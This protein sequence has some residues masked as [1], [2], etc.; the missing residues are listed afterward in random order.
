[1][2]EPSW[3][4]GVSPTCDAMCV[5]VFTC[6]QSA[7]RQ[8]YGH[9][10]LRHLVPER[11]HAVTSQTQADWLLAVWKAA[12]TVTERAQTLLVGLDQHTLLTHTQKHSVC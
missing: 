11:L 3:G 9:F 8:V 6:Q 5:C 4:G 12:V 1:M 7:D 2:G 10:V